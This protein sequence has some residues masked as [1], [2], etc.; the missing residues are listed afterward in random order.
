MLPAARIGDPLAHPAG[1][2]TGAPPL[3]RNVLVEGRPP[4]VVGDATACPGFQPPHASTVARGSRSVRIGGFNAARV[5]DPA[6][7]GAAVVAG[8]SRVRIGG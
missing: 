3:V 6:G 5:T 4:A 7:C 1:A 2:I 8:A